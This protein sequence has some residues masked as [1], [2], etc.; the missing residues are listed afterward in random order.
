MYLAYLGIDATYWLPNG[1]ALPRGI[2]LLE[3]TLLCA[4]AALEERCLVDAS[5]LRAPVA[6]ARACINRTGS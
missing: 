1:D 4:R 2:W 5:R 6:E 3:A